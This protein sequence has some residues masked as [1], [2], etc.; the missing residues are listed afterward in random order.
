MTEPE[1]KIDKV[2]ILQK[3]V[4]KILL[5]GTGN[6]GKSTLFKQLRYIFG[7]IEENKKTEQQINVSAVHRCINT[8]MIMIL[9]S[10]QKTIPSEKKSIQQIYKKHEDDLEEYNWN[11][12]VYAKKIKELWEEE[13]IKDTFYNRKNLGIVSSA[14]FFFDNILRFTAKNYIPTKQDVLLA[15]DRTTG[16]NIIRY[17]YIHDR[18]IRNEIFRMTAFFT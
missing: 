13:S 4:L 5:L 12:L 10:Y 11:N 16:M 15:K 1:S 14:P 6:S 3:P 7:N 8:Q 17:K 9:Q 2:S 18:M